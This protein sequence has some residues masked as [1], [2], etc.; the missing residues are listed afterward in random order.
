MKKEC[1]KFS[2]VYEFKINICR[3]AIENATVQ[4]V[5]DWLR[6]AIIIGIDSSPRALKQVNPLSQMT[7]KL[8]LLN[9]LA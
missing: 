3:N 6:Y 1:L 5:F 8:L 4:K 9:S 7:K 2:I